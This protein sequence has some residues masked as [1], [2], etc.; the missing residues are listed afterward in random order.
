MEKKKALAQVNQR[1][2]QGTARSMSEAVYF[3]SEP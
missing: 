3:M 1:L 2:Q